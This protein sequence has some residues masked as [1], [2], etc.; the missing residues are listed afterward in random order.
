[1]QH[2]DDDLPDPAPRQLRL[3]GLVLAL[4]MTTW[5]STAA[6]LG[7]LRDRLDL[8]TTAASLLTIAVQLGFVVGAVVSSITGLAD[9]MSSGRLM[10]IGA[11]AASALNALVLLTPDAAST[12]AVRF[13]TGVA[14]ALVYPA[15]LRAVSGWFRQGRGRAL[16]MMVAALTLGSALP[17]LLAAAGGVDWRLTVALSSVSTLGAGLL[18]EVALRDGPHLGAVVRFDRRQLSAVMRRREFRIATVGYLGHMWELYAMWAWI[19]VFYAER[20]PPRQAS[21][22]AFAT[23]AVGGLGAVHAGRQSDRHGRDAAAV[24]ALRWSGSVAVVIGFLLDAPWPILLGAGLVWG[25]WVVADSA[26]FSAVVSEHT[27][28]R[29]AGTAL[30]LQLGSGF[31]L[32]V[33]TIFAIPLVVDAGGWGWAFA[34]LAPGPFLGAWAMRRLRPPAPA[35]GFANAHV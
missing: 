31:V 2:V 15:G 6:V 33:L 12:T 23:I 5:F 22:A 29:R 17:H 32:S 19:G 21:L 28:P 25:F 9:R 3:T 35:P 18:A 10:A 1:M 16:G 34:L 20:W 30:T 7:P 27:D 4:G 13:G 14:L 26:Q 8:G 11:V 24:E